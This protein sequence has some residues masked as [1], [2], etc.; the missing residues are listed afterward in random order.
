MLS[1]LRPDSTAIDIGANIGLLSIPLLAAQS[2]LQVLSIEPSPNTLA[3]LQRTIAG[4]IYR[5]RW[6]AVPVAVG[7]RESTVEFFCAS[8]PL[9]VYDG[10]RDTRRAGPTQRVRVPLT[11]VDSIWME[12]GR[13]DVCLLKID[14]EG[15]EAL[16]I[17]GAASCLRAARPLVLI[18]WNAENLRAFN[19]A[20]DAI[21]PLAEDLGYTVHAVP[22]LTLASSP[23]HLR[24]LM[25][26]GE[27]FVL[28]P[29]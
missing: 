27:S 20:S 4:S 25:L 12:R 14:V 24:A 16:V 11:T 15:G 8:A 19:C 23:A 18:E 13:P 10:L 5:S 3:C 1:A 26:L 2:A 28:L 29:R 9:A 21:L 17:K 6:T 22:S 7:D